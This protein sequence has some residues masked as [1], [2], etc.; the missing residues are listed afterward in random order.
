M[1]KRERVF[2][3]G[4]CGNFDRLRTELSASVRI[5]VCCSSEASHNEHVISGDHVACEMLSCQGNLKTNQG[6]MSEDELRVASHL[7][8]R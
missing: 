5:G 6:S 2:V 4:E 7:R 8:G 3:C 1:S